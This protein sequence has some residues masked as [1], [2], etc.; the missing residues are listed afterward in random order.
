V[1]LVLDRNKWL[2][3]FGVDEELPLGL[4]ADL[5]KWRAGY[6]CEGCPAGLRK[7]AGGKNNLMSH[8]KLPLSSGGKTTLMNGICLCIRCHMREHYALRLMQGAVSSRKQS[9]IR[10][11]K[12]E[13]T[14]S[15]LRRIRRLLVGSSGGVN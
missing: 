1:D 5:V 11:T 6:R 8:H 12:P 3:V 10:V 7:T 13:T 14:P 2:L 15:K 9:D 4:W